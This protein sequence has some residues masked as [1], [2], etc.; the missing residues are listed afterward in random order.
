V[1]TIEHTADGFVI[2]RE[3]SPDELWARK[4]L[5]ATGGKSLPKTGSDGLG[6]LLAKSLGHTITPRV[7]PALVPLTLD[8]GHFICA[9]SGLTVQAA[10]QVRSSAGKRL[11]SFTNSTLCTHFGLSGPS[12][13]DISRY[14]LDAL[15]DSRQQRQ[16][17]PALIINWLPEFTADQFERELLAAGSRRG[18]PSAGRVL[19]EHLPERLAAALAAHAQIDPGVPVSLLSRDQ[20][21]RLVDAVTGMPLPVT[22][23]RGFLFAEVTAGG[24]PL[25][26]V[27]LKT[28]ESKRTGGLYL[29]GE[30][31][32]VDGRIGGFNFQ[33]A[34]ASGCVAGAAAAVAK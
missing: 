32:D 8:R 16:D 27:N 23:D 1:E 24:I 31:C 12:V 15:A 5:L 10:L 20:R 4:V 19:R 6:Y 7:F 3:G 2:R 34:W 26:Q 28:M 22:G 33:W 25:E 13:L 29:C 11:A 21:R 9:L 30:I 14:Y 17:P 18:A